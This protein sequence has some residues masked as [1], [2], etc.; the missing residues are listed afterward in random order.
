M[1]AAA[2]GAVAKPFSTLLVSARGEIACRVIRTAKRLG[3][4][5]VAVYSDADANSLH[6]RAADAARRLGGAA[7]AE[8]Y[9][10]IERILDAAEAS[11]AG[12]VHPGYG[13]LSENADFAE[14][15]SQR[16]LVFVGPPAGV[17]RAMG[18]KSA[19]RQCV[20][21]AGVPIIP[22]YHESD[23]SDAAL[24]EAADR[25]GYP[26]MV[27]PVMGGGGK[28]MH[29]VHR[30]KDMEAALSAARHQAKSSFGNDTLL[31]EKYIAA[32]R[33]VEV[34][35]FGDWHGNVVHIFERDCSVQ[36]RHQ[37]IIEEAP[38]PMLD[39]EMRAQMH[40]AAV[41]TA[42][43]VGYVGAGTVEFIV[44]KSKGINVKPSAHPFYFLEM[45]T[46]LQVEHPVTEAISGIDLVEWQLA[47]AAGRPIPV[48]CQSEISCSG[49]AME[50]RIYAESPEIGFMPQA[51]TFKA[52]D[53]G[54]RPIPD[55][56]AST[57]LRVDI[58]VEAPRDSVSVFYD[59]LV[60]KVISY[61]PDRESARKRLSHALTTSTS[62]GLRTNIDF[63]A[64]IL[65]ADEFV[66]GGFDT[67]MLPRNETTLLT[68]LA[69]VDESAAVAA[70]GIFYRDA[71]LL[72]ITSPST[73]AFDR[74]ALAGFRVNSSPVA[75]IKLHSSVDDRR[76]TVT[77][78]RNGNEFTYVS[79]IVSDD[80]SQQGSKETLKLL[81][82][83]HESERDSLIEFV[84]TKGSSASDREE[85]TVTMSGDDILVHR[86][87]FDRFPGDLNARFHIVNDVIDEMI[88][89][90]SR[91]GNLLS[92]SPM[93]G[94][95]VRLAVAE[96][97]MVAQGDVLFEVE[98][99]KMMHAVKAGV[100]GRVFKL[101]ANL[102]DL[103]DT[104][105]IVV[106]LKA[107]P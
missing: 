97:D 32:S 33:H 73:V 83:S 82:V 28:G 3:L 54:S 25:V 29:V 84:F 105:T 62:F 70:L 19:A 50:A 45:N 104:D 38:A 39:A 91:G 2:A 98:A 37:K 61:G 89:F 55:L 49:H 46:R 24:C 69:N 4:R 16:G 99:M 72:R 36:R 11:G 52:L 34:Q 44:D 12:A 75:T 58:G 43:Q 77:L 81:D 68:S 100:N 56:L 42:K 101:N 93:P 96:G 9:L 86:S 40:A 64:R 66:Q 48:T 35:V 102:D 103:V 51:G 57:K 87:V 1:A 53:F 17:L 7:P 78:E 63:C 85:A 5:T 22:G 30:R 59:P 41:A 31:L 95:I 27:K 71:D 47:V 90:S 23:Q 14:A 26:V 65:N 92:S 20:S 6:A 76:W 88:D 74:R 106:E 10:H 67:G 18:S 107:S 13:F 60:A 80:V 94:R 15:C 21:E 79:A 8:S